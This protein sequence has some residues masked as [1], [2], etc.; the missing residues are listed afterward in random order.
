MQWYNT[1][2]VGGCKPE[3]KT[4]WLLKIYCIAGAHTAV[5]SRVQSLCVE[6]SAVDRA[7][8]FFFSQTYLKLSKVQASSLTFCSFPQRILTPYAKNSIVYS[9]HLTVSPCSL[10]PCCSCGW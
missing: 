2:Y 1:T 5:L 6:Y 9:E 7:E 4:A 10:L 3:P 8:R